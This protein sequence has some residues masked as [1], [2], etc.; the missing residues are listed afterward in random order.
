MDSGLE[1]LYSPPLLLHG[2]SKFRVAAI[3]DLVDGLHLQLD[4]YGWNFSE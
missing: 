2:R 1:P 4:Q 3:R